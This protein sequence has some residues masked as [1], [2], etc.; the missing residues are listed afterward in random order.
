MISVPILIKLFYMDIDILL[1]NI[2]N[3][4]KWNSKINE[5]SIKC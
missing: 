3:N 5:L 4:S 1:Y 2:I